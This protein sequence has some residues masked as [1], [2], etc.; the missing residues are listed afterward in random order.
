[1]AEKIFPEIFCDAHP[2]WIELYQLSCKLALENIDR[3]K[4]KGWLPQMTCMPGVGILWQWDSCFMAMFAKYFNGRIAPMNN[5]DNLY[6]MQREDGYISMAYRI[7][8]ETPAY[9]E[10]VNP[11]LYSWVE[12]EY[13]RFTGNKKRLQRVYPILVKYF[14]FL[15]RS[16]TRKSGLYYFEDTGSS[17]MDNSPRSGYPASNLAGSDVCFVDLACQQLLNARN[18]A[19]IARILGKEEEKIRFEEEVRTLS[20]LINRHHWKDTTGFYYDVF[21]DTFNAVSAKTA[22]GFWP[23][24]SGAADAE[25]I[26]RLAE[27][28]TDP[29]EFWTQ[30]PVPTLSKD[31]PNYTPFGGYW[32][33][34]VWAPTNYM[35]VRGLASR[36]LRSLAREIAVRHLSMMAEVMKNPAYGS[37]WEC[38]APESARPATKNK[39]D[40]DHA[41]TLVRDRFVGWSA[42]GPVSMLIENILG[43][44]FNA[45]EKLVTW[46]LTPSTRHGIRH[47]NFAGGTVS[48]LC[49]G[50]KNSRETDVEIETDIPFSLDIQLEGISQARPDRHEIS[51]GIT[52]LTI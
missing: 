24:L 42:L 6:R 45:P 12:W 16:R 34:S 2:E 38:Y 7:Q 35:I 9:G 15:K 8:Q 28:L 43:L 33:G 36:G 27:H 32:L 46:H 37:I 25:Q 18:L 26:R 14:D 20:A 49:S 11:P 47:L 22:A 52:R 44:D 3:P 41:G 5:L 40:G 17:G 19:E 4:K 29:K 21:Q 39:P 30:H 31:D 13:Y 48:L 50:R 23:I 51:P 1:M 10:R